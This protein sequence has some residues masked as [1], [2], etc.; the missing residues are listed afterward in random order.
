MGVG[1]QLTL[2]GVLKGN[3]QLCTALSDVSIDAILSA[4]HSSQDPS[5][6]L[7]LLTAVASKPVAIRM[8]KRLLHASTFDGV[9]QVGHCCVACLISDGV[10]N[11][12][13]VVWFSPEIIWRTRTSHSTVR[14]VGCCERIFARARRCRCRY[15]TVSLDSLRIA[16]ITRLVSTGSPTPRPSSPPKPNVSLSKVFGMSGRSNRQAA[17][18]LLGVIELLSA[19]CDSSNTSSL[20]ACQVFDRVAKLKHSLMTIV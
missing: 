14:S 10:L 17:A 15:C 1:A 7:P 16:S 9:F 11:T 20:A 5:L 2:A 13:C 6:L 4:A 8:L 18:S 3:V 19:C 12:D